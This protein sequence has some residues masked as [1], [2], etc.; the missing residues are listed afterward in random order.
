MDQIIYGNNDDST[1]KFPQGYGQSSRSSSQPEGNTHDS[2]EDLEVANHRQLFG[3]A[4]VDDVTMTNRPDL[5]SPEHDQTDR[6]C[7]DLQKKLALDANHLKIALLTS[8]CPPEERHANVVF[9][10]AAFHQLDAEKHNSPVVHAYNDALKDFVRMK[11]RMFLLIPSLEAYSNNPHKDGTLSKSLYYLTLDALE[12]K[13]DDWKEDHLPPAV[14]Q[15]DSAALEL[16][17][18]VLETQRILIKGDVPD[19]DSMLASFLLLGIYVDLCQ[20]P[21]KQ[22]KDVQNTDQDSSYYECS[23]ANSNGLCKASNGL[24]LCSHAK[25]A[26]T[27]GRNRRKIVIPSNFIERFQQAHAHL[28]FLKD[29]EMFSHKK[30][31]KLILEELRDALVVPTLHDV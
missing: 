1:I 8:K 31:F 26:I 17:S 20:S 12:K 4:P 10:N 15:G 28:V 13:S 23:D 24:L 7:A 16:L 5:V 3:D 6:V 2:E 30:R 19:R 9:A 29:D 18:N 21:T 11:A 25:Q 14:I 22:R 27:V